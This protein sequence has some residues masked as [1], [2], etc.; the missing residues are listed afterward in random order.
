[1]LRLRDAGLEIVMHVHD[2]AVLEVPIDHSGVDEVCAL[3]AEAPAWAD[4]LPL[5]ATAMNADSIKRTEEKNHEDQQIQPRG[6]SRPY[7]VSGV[8]EHP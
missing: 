2:E 5:R 7:A 6:L 8:S 1:M 4:G 3:M